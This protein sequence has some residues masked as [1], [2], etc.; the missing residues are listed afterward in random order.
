MS[1]KYPPGCIFTFDNI[2]NDDECDFLIKMIDKYA[3][4]DYEMY[5][6]GRNVIADSINSIEI[7]DT[8]ERKKVI[9]MSFEKFR[10]FVEYLRTN[11]I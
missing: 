3:I 4:I 10:V 8:E 2:F 5:G 11:V 6:H 9:D 1:V 7:P